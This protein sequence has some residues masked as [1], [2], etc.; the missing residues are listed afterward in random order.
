[1]IDIPIILI[2]V[3]FVTILFATFLTMFLIRAAIIRKLNGEFEP[4]IIK[5]P[6]LFTK[7]D[8]SSKTAPTAIPSSTLPGIDTPNPLKGYNATPL[9]SKFIH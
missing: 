3:V 5:P 2:L 9:P 1:M 8:T 4:T 7:T 6:S